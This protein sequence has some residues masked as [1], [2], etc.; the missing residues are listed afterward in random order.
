ML[1]IFFFA[2]AGAQVCKY[3]YCR[4][5]TRIGLDDLELGLRKEGSF[6]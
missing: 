3:Y 1:L 6:D 4:H 5:T 2:F